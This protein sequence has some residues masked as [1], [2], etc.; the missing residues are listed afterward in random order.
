MGVIRL[1]KYLLLTAATVAAVC[2][3]LLSPYLSE[4]SAVGVTVEQAVYAD[5]ETTVDCTGT[6]QTASQQTVSYGYPVMAKKVYVKPGDT[7]KKGQLLLQV[8]R[9]ETAAAFAAIT[10]A[11]AAA[12]DSESSDTSPGSSDE[13]GTD[14][15]SSAA[16]ASIEQ[17]LNGQ[18]G[19]VGSLLSEYY[20]AGGGS[21]V[22]GTSS[23]SD[24]S[25]SAI[26][27]PDAVYASV[28]GVV[29]AVNAS[30]DTFTQPTVPLVVVSDTSRMQV[31]SQVDESQIDSVKTGQTVR[32]SGDAFDGTFVGQVSQIFPTAR[33]VLSGTTSTKTVVD[34]IVDVQNSDSSVKS[35]MNANTSIVTST[36]NEISLPYEALR[37]DSRNQMY[38]I[39]VRNGRVYRQNVVTGEEHTDD[40][41]IRG[42]V[43]A[44]DWI[45]SNPSQSLRSGQ[46]VRTT[47]AK[48]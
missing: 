42:G 38:V 43:R 29:T 11:Q 46:L 33:T 30:E 37:Q 44:G 10:A 17:Y 26:S 41:A 19:D 20:G 13:S 7:V 34:V 25:A 32:I 24:S 28:S 23:D 47:V 27:V 22:S 6:F 48:G 8:D 16:D 3:I 36:R 5:A 9:N 35:G 1:K 21:A 40:I 31:K 4:L 45:V 39:V 14:S 2:W 12:S 15:S 18:G